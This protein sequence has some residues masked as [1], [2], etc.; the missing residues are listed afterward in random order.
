MPWGGPL[1]FGVCT[2]YTISSVKK[3]WFGAPAGGEDNAILKASD[4]PVELYALSAVRSNDVLL[5]TP[6]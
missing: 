1:W 6:G 2:I 4:K 3:F 5:F